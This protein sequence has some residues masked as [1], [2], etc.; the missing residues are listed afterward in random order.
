[1]FILVGF[2]KDQTTR[3]IAVNKDRN[4]LAK[5]AEDLFPATGLSDRS[6]GL[7]DRDEIKGY[8]WIEEID[9]TNPYQN[10][11]DFLNYQ[12]KYKIY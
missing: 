1:M 4:V 12:G 6:E 10:G 8:F 3:V 2:R 5:I 9:E 7:W 11:V